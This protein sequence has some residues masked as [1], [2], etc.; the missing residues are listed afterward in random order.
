MEIRNPI[1]RF[2]DLLLTLFFFCN[3]FSSQH[4]N[5]LFVLKIRTESIKDSQWQA[6]S[7]FTL[8]SLLR[9]YQEDFKELS[10]FTGRVKGWVDWGGEKYRSSIK[11]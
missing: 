3:C 10:M 2:L 11:S 1:F 4:L 8:K 7:H 6:R 5:M 9:K